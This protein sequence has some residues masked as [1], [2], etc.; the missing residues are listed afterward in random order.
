MVILLYFI[1][2]YFN[3]WITLLV[4]SIYHDEFYFYYKFINILKPKF[5]QK[6]LRVAFFLLVNLF[7]YL[8][9]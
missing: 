1:L 9:N 2:R 5:V 8:G 4:R 3:S 6:F 7:V